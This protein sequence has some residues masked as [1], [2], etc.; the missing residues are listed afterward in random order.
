[1]ETCIKRIALALFSTQCVMILYRCDSSVLV[2]TK[3]RNEVIMASHVVQLG[4]GFTAVLVST[5]T[6]MYD[7]FFSHKFV[8]IHQY[9]FL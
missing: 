2:K 8:Y 3:C 9:V 4:I 6:Y 1:M 5:C 7:M